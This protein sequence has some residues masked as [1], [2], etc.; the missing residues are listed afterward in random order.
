MHSGHY[1]AY[2][3]GQNVEDPKK[4][5]KTWYQMNDSY[6]KK[7]EWKDVEKDSPYLLFYN[8][9]QTKLNRELKKDAKAS[10]SSLK[11]RGWGGAHHHTLP[12]LITLTLTH[13]RTHARPGR[14][15][16]GSRS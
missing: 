8:I 13:P 1:Y 14:D 12:H 16:R 9:K 7:V 3:R 11:R 4:L 15:R 10:Q 5:G 2:V 6:V